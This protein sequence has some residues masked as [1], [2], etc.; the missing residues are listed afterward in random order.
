M[1][2]I[3]V[4]ND[5]N[6]NSR[7]VFHFFAFLS[8]KESYSALSVSEKYELA[9]KKSR[10]IGGK[11]YHNKSYGGGI[12]IQSHNIGSTV[13]RIKKIAAKDFKK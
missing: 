9:L 5:I 12:S 10:A 3:R 6:G 13:A 2:Y 7:Y 11:K 1:N 8:R 4:N